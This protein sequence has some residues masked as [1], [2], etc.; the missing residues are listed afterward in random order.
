MTE[1]YGKMGARDL[2]L[3]FLIDASDSM[4]YGGKIETLNNAV[5][6]A[7]PHIRDVARDAEGTIRVHALTFSTGARWLVNN[8]DIKH[9]T[10]ENIQPKGVTDM[11]RSFELLADQLTTEFENIR[12]YQPVMI[13]LSDGLPTDDYEKGLEK[14]MATTWGKKA[15]RIAIAIGQEADMEVL[16]AFIGDTFRGELKPLQ[17]K[18]ASEL[19][20]YIRWASTAVS[21]AS[22]NPV[23]AAVP[24]PPT[25]DA[26]V[27][28]DDL[29]W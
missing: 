29:D 16:Q 28:M 11:G 6:E 14:L 17:A 7:I 26:T 2:H 21:N 27:D 19:K 4:K 8:V 13:L 12:G 1:N 18:N 25:A 24:M 23:K 10:W 3:F 9:F 22:I 15:I 20:H 5:R